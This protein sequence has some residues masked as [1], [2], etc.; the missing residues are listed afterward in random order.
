[1]RNEIVLA[2]SRNEQVSLAAFDKMVQQIQQFLQKLQV[3]EQ[4]IKRL[5]VLC[6]KN[7][8]DTKPKPSQEAK[9]PPK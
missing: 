9:S 6:E 8:I 1:M 3:K 2:H 7:K 5:E 4:E